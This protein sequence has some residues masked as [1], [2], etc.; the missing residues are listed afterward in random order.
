MGKFEGIYI[1]TI[2][3]HM[4]VYRKELRA[5]LRAADSNQRKAEL[6]AIVSVVLALSCRMCSP[7][8][9]CVLCI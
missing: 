2:Y 1:Y 9:E 4:H 7:H 3:L 8:L 6:Q 5:N